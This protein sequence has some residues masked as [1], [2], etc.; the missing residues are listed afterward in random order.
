MEMGSPA[1]TPQLAVPLG[2]NRKEAKDADW[3]EM[4][5]EIE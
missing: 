4:L 3:E 2:Q 5:E 1:A